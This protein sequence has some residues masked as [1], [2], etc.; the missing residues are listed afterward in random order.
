M[1]KASDLARM[2]GR[3]AYVMSI[4]TN[5]SRPMTDKESNIEP[6]LRVAGN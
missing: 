6:W 1:V 3:N 5:Q 4:Q 2:H